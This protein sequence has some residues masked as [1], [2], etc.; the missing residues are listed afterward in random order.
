LGKYV[1]LERK[2]GEEIAEDEG[3]RSR[4]RIVR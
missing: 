2:R 4:R 1:K 3:E